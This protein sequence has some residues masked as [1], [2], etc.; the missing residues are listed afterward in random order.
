MTL[1]ENLADLEGHAR[2]FADRIGFTYTVL[3]AG[4][5]VVGCLYIYPS[6]DPEYDSDVRSWVRASHANLDR[7]VWR[8]VTDWL[9]AD[10]PFRAVCYAG[11]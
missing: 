5:D 6:D 7:V 2:H 3:D 1:A 8:T 10:W 9:A 11:R 4:G